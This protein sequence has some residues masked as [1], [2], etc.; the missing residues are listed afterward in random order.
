[1][2]RDHNEREGKSLGGVGALGPLRPASRWDPSLGF[3]DSGLLGRLAEEMYGEFAFARAASAHPR[4]TQTRATTRTFSLPSASEKTP[5][6]KKS[7]ATSEC[8]KEA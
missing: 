7:R 4:S 1:M 2:M 8:F 5:P 3:A 6:K